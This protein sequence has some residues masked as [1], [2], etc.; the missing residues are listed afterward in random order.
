MKPPPNEP[1]SSD[2]ETGSEETVDG[3]SDGRPADPEQ[4]RLDDEL[5]GRLGAAMQTLDPPPGDLEDV[6]MRALTWDVE[7]ARLAAMVDDEPV[8]VR[9]SSTSD[10]VAESDVI[11]LSYEVGDYAIDL[12]VEPGEVGGVT[13]RGIVT[14]RVDEVRLAA[15]GSSP[16]SVHCDDYGRFEAAVESS[17]VA[18]EFTGADNQSR[19]TPLLDF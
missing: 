18:V 11:D 14:P 4:D 8:L 17:T 6:A 2:P 19:R 12:T 13:L 5:L 15:P 10:F 16:M 1:E 9:D 7:L 3:G